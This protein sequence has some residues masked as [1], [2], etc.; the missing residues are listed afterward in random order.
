M[1]D[2]VYSLTSF[3][4]NPSLSRTPSAD[5]VE[6]GKIFFSATSRCAECHN[7]PS[8]SNQHF[9]DKR[10][11]PTYPIGQQG[12]PE[13]PNPY[14]RHN[15]ATF[16]AFDLVDPLEVA[17]AIG[18]FQNGVLPIPGSRGELLDYVTPTLVD[19]WNTGPYNHDGGF[20]SL[21]HGIFPCDTTLDPCGGPD[22][23]KNLNDQHGT[24]SNLTP[25]QLRQLEAF[26]RAPHNASSG[27][28]RSAAPF[29]RIVRAQIRCSGAAD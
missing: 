15:V 7:G 21:L 3:V 11:D 9:S 20:A 16:N 29:T 1:A 14:I 8:A 25:Q 2:Y 5:A 10:P 22:T 18:Q 17:T 12:R 6:G 13:S 4:T 23:G 24:T 28:V 26:L 19:V 27:P